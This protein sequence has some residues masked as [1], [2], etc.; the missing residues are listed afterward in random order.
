MP[1]SAASLGKVLMLLALV[2]IHNGLPCVLG[3]APRHLLRE[4]GPP[5]VGQALSQQC[6]W[7]RWL[8]LLFLSANAACFL[9]A[10]I[11]FPRCLPGALQVAASSTPLHTLDSPRAPWQPSNKHMLW[12]VT[13]AATRPSTRG[14][15]GSPSLCQR[16]PACPSATSRPAW[17]QPSQRPQ[18]RRHAALESSRMRLLLTQLLTDPD[19]VPQGNWG[20]VAARFALQ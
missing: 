7:C 11:P 3:V 12:L 6:Y 15:P 20:C 10:Q 14:M 18:L 16:P 8:L 4:C 1:P 9:S 5:D 17:L 13:A 2:L 19:G